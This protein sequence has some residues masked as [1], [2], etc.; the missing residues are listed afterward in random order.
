MASA[1]DWT[2]RPHPQTVLLRL[3]YRK[4]WQVFHSGN[5]H[6]NHEVLTS[7][8]LGLIEND[9]DK[10]DSYRL[11]TAMVGLRGVTRDRKR[12]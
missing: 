3:T 7:K 9:S 11:M 8:L 4:L 10:Y 12:Q 5:E 2:E 6:G 1:P